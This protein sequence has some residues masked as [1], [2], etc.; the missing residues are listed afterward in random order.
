MRQ[1]R[2]AAISGSQYVSYFVIKFQLVLPLG[3]LLVLIRVPNSLFT[4]ILIIQ[5]GTGQFLWGY[6]VFGYLLLTH[7]FTAT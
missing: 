5:C 4:L 3:I 1:L 7:V 2:S 6:M